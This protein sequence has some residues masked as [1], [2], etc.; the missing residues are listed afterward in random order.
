MKLVLMNDVGGGGDLAKFA[1]SVKVKSHI[2]P[3][4]DIYCSTVFYEQFHEMHMLD[5]NTR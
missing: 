4:T 5:T 1:N 2:V 3:L